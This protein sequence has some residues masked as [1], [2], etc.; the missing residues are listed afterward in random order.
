LSLIC[1]VT[2]APEEAGL[3]QLCRKLG[4][5]EMVPPE[6]VINK[7]IVYPGRNSWSLEVT[8][9]APIYAAWRLS[10]EKSLAAALGLTK[11]EIVPEAAPE[12]NPEKAAAEVPEMGNETE[13]STA[14]GDDISEEEYMAQLEKLRQEREN[15]LAAEA[16][17]ARE[18][19][20]I[21]GQAVKEEP[22]S[23][24]QIADEERSVVVT[25]R[26]FNLNRREMRS[27]RTLLTFDITD[28]TDSLSVKLFL[29]KEDEE[30]ASAIKEGTWLM[31]RGA[32]QHDNFT[33][34]LCL[35]PRD[36]MLSPPRGVRLDN[37]AQKRVELHLH[38]K[39]S[40][41][42]GVSDVAAV[43]AQAAAWKHEAVAITDHG[44]VQA[45]PSAY[46][47]AKK[48]GVKCIFGV[49]G[50][51]V[52]QADEKA[53]S[54]HI[55]I[56][57]ADQTGLR[58][59]YEL[60]SLS[61][62]R[63][64]YR[65]PRLPRAEL[66]RLRQGLVLGSAC[67]AG[68]I[69]K[70]VLAGRS[71]AEV[72]ALAAFY[73]YLEI[74]PLSNNSFLLEQGR[75]AS[76]DDL[77]RLNRRIVEIG[78][79]LGKPVVATSDAHYL[80]P[81]DEI[82]RRILLAGQGYAEVE[83]PAPLYYKTTEEMLAEFSYLGEEEAWRVVVEDSRRV[84]AMI[85]DDLMPVPK[86]F[87]PPELPDADKI[88]SAMVH[89][90]A[91]EIY[92]DPLPQLV[93]ERIDKELAAIIGH[94]F[95]SLYLIAHKL[96]KQSVDDGYAVGS[97]GSVGS[98]IVAFLCG[99]SEVN[100]L[101]PHYICLRCHKFE[102]ITDGSVGVGPD[103][104]RR[105]CPNCGTPMKRDGFDI[106]FE[107]FLGFAGDK[108]PDIDLNFSEEYQLRAHKN[109][110]ELFGA[111]NVFRAGTIGTL[112]EK[113]AY[114][115]V[116]KYLDEKGLHRRSAEINRLVAGLTGVRKTTGQHPG[117][118]IILPKGREIYEF[119]P[120]QYPAND[121]ESNIITTHFSFDDIHEQLLK[122]DILGQS[123]PTMQKMLE[124]L[125]GITVDQIPLDDPDTMAIFRGL[126]SLGIAPEDAG[127]PI[128]TLGI[129]EYNTRYVRQMLEETRP[130]N[131]AEL[132]GIM[133]LSHGKGLWLDNAQ[134][135][136]RQGIV[137]LEKTILCR[138]DIMLFLIRQG[139]PAKDAFRITELVR[140]TGSTISAAD[141][142]LMLQY[143]VPRWYIESCK[144][145][146][147]MFP[148]AHAA[149]YALNA[150]WQ[151]YAKV[152]YPLFFYAAYFSIHAEEFDASWATM[153]KQELH[154]KL[155]A[156][157]EK[158]NAATGK[159][160]GIAATLEVVIEALARGIRFLPVDLYKSQVRRFVP[161]DGKLRLP[162]ISVQGVGLKA[163]EAIEQ[164][165]EERPFTSVEDIKKRCG[166][167][168]TV[169]E[170][171]AAYGCLEHLPETNQ[172]TL[173]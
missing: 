137:P 136:V 36:I 132:I 62:L 135:L 164:S 77:R 93:A 19:K 158:G 101:A 110:E 75:V 66:T 157:N 34:E 139:M 51:L 121:R 42:D 26:V 8:G 67:E 17:A 59:L 143:Q 21:M 141:E 128:G 127:G 14:A 126:E 61:H 130:K 53:E 161:E 33:Q 70:A 85:A 105:D 69:Y 57:A 95:A 31:L 3:A 4:I 142:E 125:T 170:V 15:Q 151:A 22:V 159:E 68:E 29:E 89:K 6:T 49:E 78:R 100:P 71:D 107:T 111:E 82:F 149:A 146:T 52:D 7:V 13:T 99:I 155:R 117:G 47:A 122:L 20:V 97:R 109:T 27:G 48:H 12:E 140:K 63:Y 44:V 37:A 119:T 35:M 167:S 171:L 55:I 115:Y 91:R 45:F 166:L 123:G 129:P 72:E 54:H 41:L 25:G 56:L 144:K 113:T 103:L 106:P 104:P 83:N 124:D 112:A 94:G 11:V 10:L 108:V 154:A 16:L 148:K 84:A 24:E 172:L 1:T 92:G 65:K 145:I 39:M 74:Q 138:D 118:L 43:F 88:I 98:T 162:L 168:K 173:F 46:K 60:I 150:Y 133:G 80:H 64:F 147:Y 152:H 153:S 96:V 102:A 169:I 58:H 50:Y 134:E 73:D 5:K 40:A 9:G 28:H 131:F 2:P 160:Q 163:A 32:V 165:R 114:G 30:K 156:L 116:R 79:R 23:L 86:G 120:I 76:L 87:Y 18:T 81:E 38:T 90:R